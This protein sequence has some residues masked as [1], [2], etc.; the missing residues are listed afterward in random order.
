M[1]ISFK[2]KLVHNC[3]R[4]RAEILATPLLLSIELSLTVS[5]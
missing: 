4:P 5:G 2:K 3:T 1:V